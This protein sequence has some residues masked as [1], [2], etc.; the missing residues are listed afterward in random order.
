MRSGSAV[1]RSVAPLDRGRLP[2]R[3]PERPRVLRLR[4]R[5]RLARPASTRLRL[6]VVRMQH[7][8]RPRP[9]VARPVATPPPSLARALETDTS[10][11]VF[12]RLC[13]VPL[14]CSTA[15][16][17]PLLADPLR[18]FRH[19]VVE[20]V[21]THPR[22]HGC[23][24]FN[25]PKRGC[26]HLDGPTVASEHDLRVTGHGLAARTIDLGSPV[27]RPL[28]TPWFLLGRGSRP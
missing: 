1:C 15:G 5:R 9:T 19:G 3:L 10:V 12:A 14:D 28:T 6:G 26:S 16:L 25:S 22:R 27:D 17:D 24:E 7:R 13:H 11:G 2:E 8:H 20:S 18:R 4:P 23:P 21:V